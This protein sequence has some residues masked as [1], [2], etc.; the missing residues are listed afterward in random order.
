VLLKLVALLRYY[1]LYYVV[2]R[3]SKVQFLRRLG[4]RI[5]DN[6][7][8]YARAGNFGSEPWLVEI[9]N[10]VTITEGVIPLTHDASSRLFRRQIHGMNPQFGNRFGTVRV[11]DNCFIGVESIIMPGVTI[12]PDS[13][14]G[15]GA[16]VTRDVPPRTVVA[17]N[18]A[19]LICSLEQYIAGYQAKMVPGLNATSRK[20]LRKELTK[21]LWGEER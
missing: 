8:I 20:A 4:A 11:L 10:N 15:A 2:C 13:I 5:G 21:A 19:R 1:G 3:G 6:C 18:P 12:G 14:V 9:G 7:H 16:V 17:G